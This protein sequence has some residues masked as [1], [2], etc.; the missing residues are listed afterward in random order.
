MK[1]NPPTPFPK[2]ER[3]AKK[4]DESSD[5]SSSFPPAGFSPS[6][7]G[8]G[9]GEGF[10][11][12]PRPSH[13]VRGQRIEEAKIRRAK[14]LRRDMTPA[15]RLLWQRLRRNQLGG[16]H[17]RRQQVIAGFIADFNCHEV[18]VVVEVDGQI[19]DSQAEYDTQ[20]SLIFQQF[21]VVVIRV[22]NEDIFQ[23]VDAVLRLIEIECQHR[24]EALTPTDNQQS[25]TPL[26]P[27][28]RK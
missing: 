11:A 9:V 4:S 5:R 20:R 1:P 14:E 22:S 17:F 13:I 3:G 2:K 26:K 25:S 8:G 28:E 19:H 27:A 6:P 10:F 16:F 21:G 15:E 7:L 23:R 24:S 12:Q 18:G